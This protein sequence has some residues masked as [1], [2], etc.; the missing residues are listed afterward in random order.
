MTS[1]AAT[2]KMVVAGGA[3]PPAGSSKEDT[4]SMEEILRARYFATA[5]GIEVVVVGTSPATEKAISQAVESGAIT[6]VVAEEEE[7]VSK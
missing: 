5:L 7:E 4:M 3:V 6:E 1:K 2:L